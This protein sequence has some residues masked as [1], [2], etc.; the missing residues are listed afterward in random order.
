MRKPGFFPRL[1]KCFVSLPNL[2]P[3]QWWFLSHPGHYHR[4]LISNTEW[5]SSLMFLWDPHPLR[6][7][8]S[9]LLQPCH[10]TIS[11]QFSYSSWT[12]ACRLSLP[13]FHHLP[14]DQ[15]PHRLCF[16]ILAS[17]SLISTAVTFIATPP[18]TP[19]PKT[20]LILCHHSEHPPLW[21]IKSHCSI[22]TI[23]CQVLTLL[24]T[25]ISNQSFLPPGQALRKSV[26]HSP[27]PILLSATHSS[28]HFTLSSHLNL[29]RKL[30][31]GILLS[32]H[33]LECFTAFSA[34]YSH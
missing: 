9:L 11:C 4:H 13:S 28:T 8:T 22:L 25:P 18:Q 17:T 20:T 2:S 1:W 3:S 19:T 6:M 27:I 5:I 29:S 32:L 33:L 16:H 30:L 21:N 24:F 23:L 14:G 12:F 15:H 26:F 10:L 7:I 34:Q 31:L